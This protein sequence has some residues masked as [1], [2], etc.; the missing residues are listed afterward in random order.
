[1][2]SIS[3]MLSEKFVE[4]QKKLVYFLVRKGKYA[5]IFIFS[6]WGGVKVLFVSMFIR[7]FVCVR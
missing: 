3:L 2:I 7:Y 6:V 4:K 1:M 5:P